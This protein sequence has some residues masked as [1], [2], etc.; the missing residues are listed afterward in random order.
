MDNPS[1]LI[2][3]VDDNLNELEL[4]VIA[5]QDV[6][7]SVVTATS[8][9]MALSL[10][11]KIHPDAVLL[12]AMMGGMDGFETCRT[13]K[14]QA[15]FSQIPVI[16]L[17]GLIEI[18]NVVRGLEAGGVDYVTK[19][20]IVAE[21]IARL[22]VHIN[23]ARMALGARIA[24]DATGRHLLAVNRVGGLIWHT[25]QAGILLKQSFK[26]MDLDHHLPPEISQIISETIEKKSE[27]PLLF[28]EGIHA[29]KIIFLWETG[30]N[31]YLFRL[32]ETRMMSEIEFL[33]L[34]FSL[35][36][37]EAEILL[38]ITRGKSNQ[39]MSDILEISIRTVD[40]HIERIFTKL[41]VENRAAA[42]STAMRSLILR[43]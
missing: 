21:L 37:R 15:K 2:L 6:G 10:I 11:E 40:K 12:D 16:F 25:P 38:W 29:I 9:E 18:E 33:K 22:R 23:N 30:Q 20:V 8:G 17:T 41:G 39:D 32:I 42:T 5:L 1:P 35:T 31:E 24:L 36:P 27:G 43:L 3:I 28:G 26:D 19:P 13:L 4:L 34:N 7:M 14:Q